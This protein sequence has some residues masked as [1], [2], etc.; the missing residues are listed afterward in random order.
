M[1][2]PNIVQICLVTN[3]IRPICIAMIIYRRLTQYPLILDIKHVTDSTSPWGTKVHGNT[4]PVGFQPTI[5]RYTPQGLNY[6]F[7][8]IPR[9]V[10]IANRQCTPQGFN[11]QYINHP[12]GFQIT[13]IQYTP[14]GYDCLN[15]CNTPIGYFERSSKGNQR[16]AKQVPYLF[17]WIVLLSFT[18][19]FVLQGCSFLLHTIQCLGSVFNYT[20]TH[21]HSLTQHTD[22]VTSNYTLSQ[23]LDM[24]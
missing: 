13:I 8:V 9:R 16:V 3:Y 18:P 23:I 24:L 5:R 15:H 11:C 21:I 12:V 1:R 20:Y 2:L 4:F 6:R 17:L 7:S 22:I 14:Q 19:P 10:S